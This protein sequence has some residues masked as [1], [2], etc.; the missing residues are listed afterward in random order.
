MEIQNHS[1]QNVIMELTDE[2]LAS[3]VKADPNKSY[4]IR[5]LHLSSGSLIVGF[6]ISILPETVMMLRPHV[7]QIAGDR[8]GEG[9]FN[10]EFYEMIPYLNQLVEYDPDDLDPTPFM[11]SNII[12][13]NIPAAHVRRNYTTITQI[14]QQYNSEDEDTVLYREYPSKDTLH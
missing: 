1:D 13:I 7:M 9:E 4:P 8:N 2:Q 3:L 14:K 5:M 10:I 12:S 6:V 11:V